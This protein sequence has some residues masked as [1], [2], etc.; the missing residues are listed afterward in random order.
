MIIQNRTI[1]V[2]LTCSQGQTRKKL[3]KILISQTAL[4]LQSGYLPSVTVTFDVIGQFYVKPFFGLELVLVII[5]VG[6]KF[7]L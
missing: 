6:A 1:S 4:K 2:A 7:R 3:H 5:R